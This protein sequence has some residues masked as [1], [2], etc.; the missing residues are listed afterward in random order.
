MKWTEYPD[1]AARQSAPVHRGTGRRTGDN[2]R[3]LEGQFVSRAPGGGCWFI[4]AD[5]QFHLVKTRL[6]ESWC[7][8]A[9]CPRN[10]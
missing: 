7:I 9:D 4:T 6:G 2:G 5:K 1:A 8:T 10:A 3:E